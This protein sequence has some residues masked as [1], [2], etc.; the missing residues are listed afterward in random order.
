MLNLFTSERYFN[1]LNTGR[2]F[3]KKNEQCSI[4]KSW[5]FSINGKNRSKSS[6]SAYHQINFEQSR[7][8]SKKNTIHPIHVCT[9]HA[10]L[11]ILNCA[12]FFYERNCV[13]F[14]V[15]SLC[16]RAIRRNCRRLKRVKCNSARGRYCECHKTLVII[17]WKPAH[18][19]SGVTL[20]K[21]PSQL[22]L[23]IRVRINWSKTQLTRD[24]NRVRG[25][26]S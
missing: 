1:S 20:R 15:N 7:R 26:L 14:F 16:M 18:D 9:I 17:N 24:R 10:F 21:T 23:Y 4:K 2:P 25:S 5:A 22:Y 6:S 8:T 11:L 19:R 13:E 3:L 12:Y